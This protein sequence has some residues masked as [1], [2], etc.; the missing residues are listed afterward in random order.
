MHRISYWCDTRKRQ[1][2]HLCTSK[3][4]KLS[5]S[6]STPISATPASCEPPAATRTVAGYLKP[7]CAFHL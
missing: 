1:Y 4:S 3:A 6:V 2:S 5:F 7:I